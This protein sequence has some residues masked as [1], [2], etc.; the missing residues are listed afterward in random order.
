[1]KGPRICGLI[2]GRGDVRYEGMADLDGANPPPACR[3]VPLSPSESGAAVRLCV[4]LQRGGAGE[5]ALVLLRSSWLGRAYLGA[6]A[7]SAG[8]VLA[9]L[10]LWVQLAGPAPGLDE[11]EA[12]TNPEVDQRWRRWV[13]AL[14]AAPAGALLHGGAEETHP[15]PVWLDPE[16][17]R[18]VTPTDPASGG[19][20]RLSTDDA[21][22][23]V[24]G[25][26]T[27][28]DSRRRFLAVPGQP[29]AG[30]LAPTGDASGS[31]RPVADAQPDGGRGLVPFN[32]EGGFLL[33]RRLAP[34]EWSGYAALLSG[35]PYAGVP[36]VRAPLKLGGPFTNLDDWDRLQQGGAHLFTGS[37]GRS[38]RFHEALHLKLALFLSMLR[39]VRAQVAA[40][41][42]PQLNLAPG[43]FRIDLTPAAGELPV[44]WT[45][46]AVL[47][48]P[49]ASVA[50]TAP[51]DLRYFKLAEEGGS[52]IYRPEG[53]G[54]TTRG[55]GELRIRKVMTG[56]DRLQ[57]EA[58]LVAPEVAGASTRD[59]VWARLP[60]PGSG[61]VDLVG[62][63]DAAEGLAQGEARFRTAPLELGAAAQAALRAAEGGVFPGT[64]FRTIP[65]LSTPVDLYSLGVLGVQLF[66]G[67]SDRPLPTLLDAT[68]SLA[69]AI[70]AGSGSPGERAA[71]VAAADPRW[72]ET[73]GPQLHGHDAGT[74]VAAAALLPL[75]LWWDILAALGRLF[76]GA[77][78]QP[79]CRDFGDA[80]PHQIDAVFAGP[81][82]A[83]EVLLLRSQSL[84]LADWPT[85][86][87][88]AK[89]IQKVR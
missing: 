81:I 65:L 44:L 89:V 16:R 82:G 49:P 38:G 46:R 17:A 40:T 30:F 26:E 1:M 47:A 55:R 39:A 77:G 69:R 61:T 50:L 20:Y 67:G 41:R 21:A 76:P 15:L 37:R 3:L 68:L 34:M 12:G 62:N 54:R 87:E 80:P 10:E 22:L 73:L 70:P 56:G 24:A 8:R 29:A 66:L 18:P 42:L 74:F 28:S 59:L 5:H 48:D 9:W 86:R 79:F 32:P 6:L 7:D 27:F 23:M 51:G 2:T 45:A 58:T 4:V 11:T 33:A 78:A 53:A 83:F 25:L 85:N 57:V 60:L 71:A 13:A 84:L 35:R 19:A 36:G 52:S 14:E 63:I 75:E 64:P 43:A 31:A 72:R 88:I